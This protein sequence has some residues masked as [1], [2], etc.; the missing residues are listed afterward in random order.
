MVS[1]ILADTSVLID[2][3]KGEEKTIKLFGKYKD[4][5]C[6]SRITACEFIYDSKDNKEK[7]INKD[8]LEELTIIEINEKISEYT[9][10]LLDKYGLG[11][12]FGISDALI[13]SMAI[14]ENLQFWTLNTRHF[15]RIKELKLFKP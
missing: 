7:K 13:L 5:I 14:V 6:I 10:S 8:F 1:K 11:M 15:R 9:Y 2:L 4:N 12:K 3:Q